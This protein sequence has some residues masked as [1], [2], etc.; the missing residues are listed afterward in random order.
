M[1]GQMEKVQR[2]GDRD[3]DERIQDTVEGEQIR[4]G[5]RDM[6]DDDAHEHDA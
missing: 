5:V 1:T 3:A 2:E 4:I 6:R